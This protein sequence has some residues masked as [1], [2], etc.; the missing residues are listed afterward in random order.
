MAASAVQMILG[1]TGAVGFILHFISPLTTAVVIVLVGLSLFDWASYAA[2]THW[3]I[4]F[5]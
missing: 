2:G 5:L 1:L 4:A 3:G